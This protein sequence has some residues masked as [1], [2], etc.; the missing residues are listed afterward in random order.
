VQGREKKKG[1]PTSVEQVCGRGI[2]SIS[3]TNVPF[4]TIRLARE[5]KE[6][7][8][9][10]SSGRKEGNR[11]LFVLFFLLIDEPKKKGGW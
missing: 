3:N 1:D 10:P 6:S 7:V 4:S 2:E 5:K 11:L 8:F 9:V